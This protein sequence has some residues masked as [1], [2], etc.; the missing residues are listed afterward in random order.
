MGSYVGFTYSTV[1][2]FISYIKMSKKLKEDENQTTFFF[3]ANN[4]QIQ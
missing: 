4:L 2:L 3:F 1:N